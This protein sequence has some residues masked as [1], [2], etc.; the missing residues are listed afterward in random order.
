MKQDKKN[1]LQLYDLETYLFDTVRPRFHQQGFLSAFDFF[2]IVIWKANR[3]KRTIAKRLL[4]Y[5]YSN[6]EDAVGALTRGLAKAGTPEDRLRYLWDTWGFRLPMAS[7]IL[8]VLFPEDFTV[9][10]LSLIHI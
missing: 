9:Y 2:C 8:A 3:A 4:R 6:L 1:Y 5:G 7:A 10:D